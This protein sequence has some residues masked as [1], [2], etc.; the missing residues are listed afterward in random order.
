MDLCGRLTLYSNKTTT[1]MTQKEAGL[2]IRSDGSITLSFALLLL[3]VPLLFVGSTTTKYGVAC[4]V[5][6]LSLAL[7]QAMQ[8][9]QEEDKQEIRFN[10]LDAHDVLKEMMDW[11]DLL[12]CKN[13]TQPTDNQ[14][15]QVRDTTTVTEDR[16]Q[17]GRLIIS[18]GLDALAKKY[19]KAEARNTKEQTLYAND[20]IVWCQQAAYIGLRTFP[21]DDNVVSSAISLLALAAKDNRVKERHLYQADN[22]GLDLP[23]GCLRKALVRAEAVTNP[24]EEQRA[25]ELQRKG[26]LLLG[27]LASTPAPSASPDDSFSSDLAL[28]IVREGGLDA[29]LEAIDWF[30]YHSDV[31]NWGL[32]AVFTLCYENYANKVALIQSN[33]IPKVLQTLQ[34]CPKSAE[35]ARHGTAI[36]FDLLREDDESDNMASTKSLPQTGKRLDIWK[37]RNMA[38]DAGIQ[39]ILVA[40]MENFPTEMDIMMMGQEILVGTGYKGEIPQF[41]PMLQK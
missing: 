2:F 18:L 28:Q 40:A 30:R 13:D 32:W 9:I 26:C 27:A 3:S 6:A 16:R 35:V 10:V 21:D 20:L 19:G 4:L 23:I 5:L 39:E 33:G 36:L 17:K 31:A 34:N 8:D 25:A 22:Y 37:I 24:G 14:H 11:Q 38:L 1:T 12:L 15:E 7:C 29:I 41:D